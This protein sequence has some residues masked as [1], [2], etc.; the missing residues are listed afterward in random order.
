MMK[1][2]DYVLAKKENKGHRAEKGGMGLEVEFRISV[3]L[4]S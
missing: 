4:Q 3:N 1:L 2:N